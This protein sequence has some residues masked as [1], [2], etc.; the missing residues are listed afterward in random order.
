MANKIITI[1]RQFGSGGREVSEQVS[2]LLGIPL[3]DRTLIEMA[4]KV[5]GI[6]SYDLE[7]IDET[8]VNHFLSLYQKP[9][10]TINTETG[11]GLP[12]NDSMH[13]TQCNIIE[14]L[15]AKNSCIIIGR[16]ADWVLADKFPCVNVFLC[17]D[18][19]DRVGRIA[20]RYGISE[21]EA[22]EALRKVDRKRKYYYETY[23]EHD[24]GK[25]SSYQAMLNVSMLKVEKTAETIASM[26]RNL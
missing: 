17:A 13:L 14:Q 20:K 1:S 10:E 3:Y 11:Y 24:W 5:M 12:L 2:K 18:Y 8:A 16:C 25:I 22:G 15:A 9:E 26:F 4:S 23:T 6:D 19:K 7:R 21:W